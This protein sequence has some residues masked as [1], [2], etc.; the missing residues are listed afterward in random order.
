MNSS[1]HRPHLTTTYA[2]WRDE[3]P[4]HFLFSV[5]LPRSITHEARLRRCNAEVAQFYGEIAYLQPK[6]AAVLVQLPPTLEFSAA[7]VRTF[8]R[9]APTLRGTVVTCEPRHAS[10]FTTAAD[11]ALRRVNVARVAADPAKHAGANVPGGEPRFAYFRWHG[12]PQMYY[13]KY[14]DTQLAA[15]ALNVTMAGAM[16]AWC[17][18]DNTARYAAWDDALRFSK[19]LKQPKTSFKRARE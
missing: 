2:R 17:V 3:T 15:F 13:S 8:F 9:R 6:L 14:S 10:W 19:M 7:I 1:F 4:A 18:F 11:E 5:K 12:T 16:T